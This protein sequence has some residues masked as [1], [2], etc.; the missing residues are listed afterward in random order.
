MA[1]E[2]RA[3]ILY[4][5]RKRGRPKTI[6]TPKDHGTEELQAKRKANVTAEP[7]DLCL[8]RGIISQEQHWCGIHLRWLYTLRYGA[9][10]VRALDPTHMGGAENKM[11][12]PVWRE[13]REQEY[14]EAMKLLTDKGYAKLLASLCIYNERPVFLETAQKN[15]AKNVTYIN[16]MVD[17]LDIL[18][19]HWRRQSR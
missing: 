14:H 4:F 17:G 11:D 6:R 7:L 1:E 13:A 18:V 12:D 10:G 8:E 9:P 16:S 19:R 5:P 2:T 3:T 15:K